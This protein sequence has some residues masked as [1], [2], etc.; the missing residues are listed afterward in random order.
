ME[1][2]VTVAGHTPDLIILSAE[3]V[4]ML[5]MQEGSQ[6]GLKWVAI[7]ISGVYPDP[8]IILSYSYKLFL[9]YI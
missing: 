8:N 1:W 5:S 9:S 7:E 2:C 4:N 3:F 6:P